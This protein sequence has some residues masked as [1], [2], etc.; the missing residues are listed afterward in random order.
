MTAVTKF[1]NEIDTI[2]MRGKKKT[3][4]T[5]SSWISGKYKE[6]MLSMLTNCSNVNIV[7]GRSEKLLLTR[8]AIA[9]LL[10]SRIFFVINSIAM[11]ENIY[12]M[13]KI[14]DIV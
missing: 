5:E 10:E 7:V 6:E 4:N 11:Q 3:I 9:G 2:R 8:S 14:N 12:M 13:T 1:I